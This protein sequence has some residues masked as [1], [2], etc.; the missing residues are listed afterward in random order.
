M[1]TPFSPTCPGKHIEENAEPNVTA[2]SALMNFHYLMSSMLAWIVEIP[3]KVFL[4]DQE[5][6]GENVDGTGILLNPAK[7]RIAERGGEW[8]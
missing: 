3:P 2:T 7:S 1:R 5:V 8:L 4:H 6:A